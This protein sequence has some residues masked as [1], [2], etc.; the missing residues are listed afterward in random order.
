MKPRPYQ[1]ETGEAIAAKWRA[2][3]S[4]QLVVLPTA[5]GKTVIFSML[6]QW[7]RMRRPERMLVLVQADELCFQAVKK[8]SAANPGLKIGLE[9]AK[10][11]SSWSDDIVVA[12]IQ[13]LGGTVPDGRGGWTWGKR[14]NG[15]DPDAFRYVVCDESHH[16]TSS[17]YHGV[18]RYF[19][20]M[21][22]DPQYND[23]SK[24]LLGVT[25]TPKRSDSKGLEGF[26]EEIVYSRDIRTM[27]KE[28]WLADIRAFRIETMVSLDGVQ[29]RQGDYAIGQLEKA[30]NSPERNNLIVDGYL[31]HGEGL[32]F[33]GFT[34]DIQ[35]TIDLAEC[36]RAR[37]I[38]ATGISGG[39]GQ[40]ESEWLVYAAEERKKTIQDYEDGKLDGLISCQALLEGFDA[41][42]ATVALCCRPTK[43][44][45]L[46]TQTVGRV[47]RPFPAPEALAGWQG[48]IKKYAIILDFVDNTSTNAAALN[49]VPTLFGLRPDFNLKGKQVMEQL[50]EIEKVKQKAPA[51]NLSLY[52][53]LEALKGVAE[54]IDLFAVPTVPTELAKFSQYAWMTG[55]TEGSYQ[56]VLPDKG[57]IRVQETTLGAF[58]ISRH[59]N[60]VK[61]LIQIVPDLG[62]AVRVAD[63]Q[64]PAESAILLKNDANWRKLPV[65]DAQIGL[66]RRLYPDMRKPFKTDSEFEKFVRTTYGRGDVSSLIA[67]KDKRGRP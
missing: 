36:F 56:L 1:V 55:L 46:Y 6:P 67:A 5:S 32:P 52:T 45:L 30:V 49:T 23:P 19:G 28:G 22:S 17:N 14:L 7:L 33:L 9:K 11:K 3:V 34:V 31:K 66:L 59:L 4:R 35:H 24:F 40:N 63:K 25:A 8:L 60:G 18:L 12:S 2:G 51:I 64:V 29:T 16:I 61:T 47:L 58:E 37:G 13:T 39:K 26:F 20:V 10:Y 53:D 57:V 15:M 21:K 38:K 54:K 44:G 27:I 65:S 41:P 50:D 42:R 43:S 48:W 62:E